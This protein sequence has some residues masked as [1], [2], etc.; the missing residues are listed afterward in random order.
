MEIRDETTSKLSKKTGVFRL[1]LIDHQ[2]M[3]TVHK[4]YS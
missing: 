4:F 1:T 2:C 3:I